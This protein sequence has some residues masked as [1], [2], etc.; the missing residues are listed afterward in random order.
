MP[1]WQRKQAV[2]GGMLQV[3]LQ[4]DVQVCVVPFEVQ[5]DGQTCE[6]QVAESLFRHATC[7][8]A[9]SSVGFQLP[10]GVLPQHACAV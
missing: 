6:G 5:V 7:T 2:A 4:V 1:F 9:A 8:P 3:K 10:G